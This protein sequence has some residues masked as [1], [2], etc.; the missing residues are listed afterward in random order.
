VSTRRGLARAVRFRDDLCVVD[1]GVF[2]RAAARLSGGGS[3]SN[4]ARL[5]GPVTWAVARDRRIC[6]GWWYCVS[7]MWRRVV[8]GQ[9][10]LVNWMLAEALGSLPVA[11]LVRRGGGYYSSYDRIWKAAARMG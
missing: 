9:A 3:C 5:T 4:A 1:F 6:H 8:P 7:S 2:G 10:S 11:E